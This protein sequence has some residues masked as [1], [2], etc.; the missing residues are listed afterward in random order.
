MND[1]TL[2]DTTPDQQRP[3]PIHPG[4][5]AFTIPTEPAA[6]V[7]P[8]TVEQILAMAKLP[9]RR[10]QICLRADLQSRYDELIAELSGMVNAQ[11]E[12]LEDAEASMGEE[13]AASKARGLEDQIRAVRREMTGSM[14]YPLF[15]G[16]PSDELTVFN[17][18]HWPAEG[19][20]LTDYNN[21]LIARCAVEPK[22]TVEQVIELR[23]TLSWKSIQDLVLKAREVNIGLGVDVPK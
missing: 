16:M 23:Q 7:L 6:P 20:D 10:A 14:W 5:E 4:A 18:K 11:G 17:K 2:G 21:L 1:Q 8:L 9:E 13:S 22:L 3:A 19:E 15:R 12:L